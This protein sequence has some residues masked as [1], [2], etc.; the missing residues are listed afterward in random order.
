VD[1]NTNLV[2]SCRQWTALACAYFLTAL[3]FQSE[4]I[5]IPPR[6]DSALWLFMAGRMDHDEFPLRDLWDN[7][8]PPIFLVGR[9]ALATSNPLAALWGIEAALTTVGALSLAWIIS[10]CWPL[11]VAMA[12]GGLYCVISGHPHFHQGGY[13]TEI[14]AA[15]LACLSIAAAIRSM[16]YDSKFAAIISGFALGLAVSFR[17]QIGVQGLVFPMLWWT[18]RRPEFPWRKV[19]ATA[20]GFAIGGLLAISHALKHGYM[21]D[22]FEHCLL[23]AFRH[24]TGGTTGPDAPTVLNWLERF[25]AQLGE[26]FWLHVPAIAAIAIT[27][28]NRKRS[29]EPT[30][31]DDRSNRPDFG[32]R[33]L[34]A[35]WYGAS[36]LS[37]AVGPNQFGHYHLLSFPAAAVWFAVFL[38]VVRNRM[39]SSA[40]PRQWRIVAAILLIVPVVVVGSSIIRRSVR[41]IDSEPHK[42]E[43]VKYAQTAVGPNESVFCWIWGREADLFY[44][45]SRSPGCKYFVPFT[46]FH[47]SPVLLER[48]ADE[49][50]KQPPDWILIDT[51]LN[52]ARLIGPPKHDWERTLE[53]LIRVRSLIAER[54]SKK[55]TFGPFLLLSKDRSGVEL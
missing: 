3:L 49:M 20:L 11:W 35:V 26:L 55:Q 14:Y 52:R 2:I 15:P 30:N 27:V 19:A 54:Y 44:R 34:L 1:K 51:N 12:G 25:F 41:P 43:V 13:M 6:A 9:A 36:L 24:G 7:K 53:P 23:E 28:R 4:T 21:P 45:I 33:R 22:V 16:S 31:T 18:I 42:R 40:R 32:Y 10:R 8:L 48:W 29:T 5:L 38:Y 17:P 47:T 46:F 37:A 39:R 50:I